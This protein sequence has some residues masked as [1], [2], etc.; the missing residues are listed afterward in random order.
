MKHVTNWIYAKLEFIFG[1]IGGSTTILTSHPTLMK[2]LMSIAL[3]A[4][5]ALGA[6]ITKT[7]IK[8][9][10]KWLKPAKQI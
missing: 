9:I 4:A 7:I 8:Y 5:G 10:S 6:H 1:I 2:I 3:G